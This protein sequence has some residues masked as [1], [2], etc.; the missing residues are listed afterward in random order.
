MKRVLIILNVLIIFFNFS[1]FSQDTNI[2]E[3]NYETEEVKTES[4]SYFSIGAA[5]TANFNFID[6]KDVNLINKQFGFDEF[7]S[8]MF[9][10]GFEIKTGTVLFKNFN[11]GFFSY[12][13]I[14]QK[15]LDTAINS[16]NYKRMSSFSAENLG[17]LLEYSFVPVKSLAISPG[18]QI[19]F[20]NIGIE[21]TQSPEKVDFGELHSQQAENSFF[22]SF[23]KS[24]LNFEPKLSIE[25]AVTTFLM[26]RVTTSYN[27]SID[28]PISGGEWIYNANSQITNIPSKI[29]LQ[30]FNLQLGIFVGL[31]NF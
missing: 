9:S 13:G 21:Y 7:K 6:F 25:Y 2:D 14:I 3:F 23:Q 11:I 15:K 26:F 31:M 20:G 1:I 10:N 27:I 4:L 18:L 8:P 16:K 28:N 22:H 17:L 30:N 24:F 12:S 19:G 29:N 5:Y